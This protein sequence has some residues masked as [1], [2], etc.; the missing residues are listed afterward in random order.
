[1]TEQHANVGPVLRPTLGCAIQ[2]AKPLVDFLNRDC[3]N[4][5]LPEV[6]TK[7]RKLLIQ[8]DNILLL[9]AA[10]GWESQRNTE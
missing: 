2:I 4:C 3:S 7:S 8:I 1:M 5:F 10:S 9:R 6:L